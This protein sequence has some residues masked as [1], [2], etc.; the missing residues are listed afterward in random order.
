[1]N[2]L[3]L[4]LSSFHWLLLVGAGILGI[5]MLVAV[6]EFGHFLFA[7]LFKVDTPSFS[8]GFGPQIFSKK[9]GNTLF[10]LSAIPLGGYVEVAGMAELGQGEQ[11]QAY[12]LDKHS[13]ATKPFYQK[14]LILFGGILFNCLFTFMVFCALFMLGAPK[15]ELLY[16]L[17]IA[18]EEP[19]IKI[20]RK[21]SAA[22]K[23]QLAVGDLIVAINN[24]QIYGDVKKLKLIT[25]SLASQNIILR[26]VRNNIEQD[27]PVTLDSMVITED[28][29]TKN[30]GMLGVFYEIKDVPTFSF[31]DAI[32]QSFRAT[33][34]YIGMVVQSFKNMFF[35]KDISGIGG[36]VMVLTET[37][38]GAQKGLKFFML[39]L[40][41]I[42]VNLAVLNLIPLP[43][44][45]GGQ[46]VF[47]TIETAIGKQ[48]PKL[49]EYIHIVS[50]IAVLILII[51]LTLKDM[52]ILSRLGF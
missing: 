36:P 3:N 24:E 10:S 19:I 27:I 43:I 25:R 49:R 7:K 8:I 48:L 1:M 31:I 34:I 13:F 38:K 12:N 45:D 42:S 16:P 2:L 40:A 30:I 22:E 46:I 52:G 39:F 4:L 50:W 51:Y 14:M 6:H 15:T 26:I 23:A 41:V 21:D 33:Y 29:Q 9:I 37:I 20:I 28:G 35:K 32:K 47:V 11:K 44:L 5:S 17:N 18:E